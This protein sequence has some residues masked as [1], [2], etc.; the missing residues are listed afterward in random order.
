[1]AKDLFNRYLWMV[2]TIR[3]HHTITRRQFNELWARSQFGNGEEMPRRTFYNYR[4]AIEELF[5]IKIECNSSTFEYFI[6][7][8]IDESSNALTDWVLNSATIS[9]LLSDMQ[10]ISDRVFLEDVP[11]A[12]LY[13]STIVQALRENREV[14]FSYHPYTRSLPATGLRVRPCFLKIFRQRWYLTGF[15]V[16]DGKIKTYALDRM[17]EVT[18]SAERYDPPAGFVAADFVRDAFGIVFSHGTVH[19]IVLK[20]EARRAKY[21]RALPLHHSQSEAIHDE[22]SI[23]TYKLRITPDFVQEIL[24]YGPDVVVLEPPTLRAMISESLKKSLDNYINK[25]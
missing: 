4:N 22:F 20:V 1:M 9:N 17:N 18:I 21:F 16:A 5:G 23:F 12:R 2:D 8:D 3:R 10:S 13:L 24:S 6:A 25:E 11:S 14:R 15:N 19:R 7:D